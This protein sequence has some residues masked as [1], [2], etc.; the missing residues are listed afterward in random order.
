M[1]NNWMV[2]VNEE[3]AM[4][5]GDMITCETKSKAVNIA[6]FVSRVL[7]NA[8]VDEKHIFV[9]KKAETGSNYPYDFS[10][11]SPFTV[12]YHYSIMVRDSIKCLFLYDGWCNNEKKL[13]FK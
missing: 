6:S 4:R 3:S 7:Y 1:K 13:C 2:V 10:E 9:V 8:D 12:V 11:D 5:G